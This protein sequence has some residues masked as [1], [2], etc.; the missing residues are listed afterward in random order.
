M[1]PW[2]AII[3]GIG[4]IVLLAFTGL[5]AAVQRYML[6]DPVLRRKGGGQSTDTEA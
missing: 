1:R 5:V 2:V 3:L 4:G 6:Q